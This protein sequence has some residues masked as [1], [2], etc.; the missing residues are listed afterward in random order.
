MREIPESFFANLHRHA[1]I[2]QDPKAT[3]H[4]GF[5]ES[6]VRAALAS[7]ADGKGAFVLRNGT[8]YEFMAQ[9]EVTVDACFV[10]MQRVVR[11]Q[12]NQV[13]GG[14]TAMFPLTEI[15]SLELA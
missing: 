14:G 10:V 5:S 7:V 3:R 9:D 4:P 13:T 12:G 11:Y 15:S 6:I 1:P 8:R 2:S